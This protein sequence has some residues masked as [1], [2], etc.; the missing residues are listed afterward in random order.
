[1]EQ[2]EFFY[3][4]SPCI[5]ICES[6]NRGYCKGCFRSRDE[7]LHWLKMTNQQKRMVIQL[8]HR[9]HRAWLIRKQQS[10][11]SQSHLEGLRPQ[12]DWLNEE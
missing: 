9:R 3:I 12:L 5:G 8:C 2:L 4:P 1:M 6:N 10:Q 7:R 11:Q